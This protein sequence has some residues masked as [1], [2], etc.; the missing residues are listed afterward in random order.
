AGLTAHMEA[1][2]NRLDRYG[3]QVVTAKP[4][5][6]RTDMTAGMKLPLMIEA[7]EAAEGILSLAEAGTGSGYIPKT[8]APIMNVIQLVPSFIFR[9]TNI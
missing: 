9:K 3:V 7:H 4:G 8:W 5:P 6:V 1:M 2:R